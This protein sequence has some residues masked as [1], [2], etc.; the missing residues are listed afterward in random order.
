MQIRNEFYIEA[1]QK[2][3]LDFLKQK[4]KKDARLHLRI[5]KFMLIGAVLI[6]FGGAWENI[7]QGHLFNVVTIFSWENYFI[8]LLSLTIILLIAIRVLQSAELTQIKKD[9][10]QK[11]KIVERV[12]I[13]RKTYLPHNNTFHFY[14]NSIQK[15]SIEVREQDFNNWKEGD[16]ISIEYSKNA[17]I[18][19]GY[20]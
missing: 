17:G 14:L 13:E 20:F 11:T 2:P 6:S 4:A 8:T 16:E 3:E 7:T 5:L 9:I 12:L 10:R 15:L 19:F 18:Y 1:M